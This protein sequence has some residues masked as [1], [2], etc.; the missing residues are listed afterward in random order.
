MKPKAKE[1]C[2]CTVPGKR[3]IGTVVMPDPHA[4]KMKNAEPTNSARA[5]IKMST[6]LSFLKN[7]LH[8]AGRPAGEINIDEHKQMTTTTNH[9]LKPNGCH[10]PRNEN[11]I[12]RRTDKRKQE[13]QW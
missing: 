9:T 7:H 4:M 12:D 6:T 13:R 11:V 3:T 8:E 1:I 5:G 10:S 2:T